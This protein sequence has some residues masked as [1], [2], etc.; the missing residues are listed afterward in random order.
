MSTLETTIYNVLQDADS[1]TGSDGLDLVATSRAIAR[2]VHKTIKLSPAENGMLDASLGY[3][4]GDL[5]DEW[6]PKE[7]RAL[8]G[9]V[10]R[11]RAVPRA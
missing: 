9:L 11:L 5:M 2:A 6:T 1:A 7:A 3:Y 10:R 4:M 8:R